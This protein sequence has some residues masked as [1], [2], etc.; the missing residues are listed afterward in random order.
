MYC[1]REVQCQRTMACTSFE[2]LKWRLGCRAR[3]GGV[4]VDVEQGDYE[5]RVGRVDLG[6]MSTG[7]ATLQSRPCTHWGDQSRGQPDIFCQCRLDNAV[8]SALA[9][10]NSLSRLL[11]NDIIVLNDAPV[12]VCRFG[13][14]QGHEA[15][16]VRV[17]FLAQEHHI[18]LYAT[19]SNGASARVGEGVEVEVGFLP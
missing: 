12:G 13:G 9:R 11:S 7:M 19:V 5:V 18:A 16:I 4:N 17:F 6:L 8:H 15:A 3:G 1:S 2:N 10:L 14:F